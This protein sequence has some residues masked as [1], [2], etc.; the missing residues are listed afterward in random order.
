M[1]NEKE[2][3]MIGVI[4]LDDRWHY[5]YINE[6]AAAIVGRRPADLVGKVIWAE[7]PLAM[8]NAC[9]EQ[10]HKSFQHNREVHFE[11]YIQS[12][13]QW[14]Q[15]SAYPYEG[16]LHIRLH[17]Q[18]SMEMSFLQD[19]TVQMYVEHAQ[20]LI[21]L[22][23]RDGIFRYVSPAIQRLLGFEVDEILGIHIFA[24]CHPED[25]EALRGSFTEEDGIFLNNDQ[26]IITCRFL[27]KNGWYVWFEMNYKWM[28]GEEGERSQK[29]CIWR[30]ITERKVVE[31]RFVQAQRLGQFGS[32]EREITKNYIL[33]SDEIYRIHGLVPQEQM[34]LRDA[35]QLILPE[36][37]EKVGLAV[38]TA[39]RQGRVEVEYR[40]TRADGELRY[41]RTQI[42]RCRSDSNRLIVR[43]L[44]HDITGHK[45]IE[46][47]LKKS[48]ANLQI[49]QE[50]AGLGHYSWDVIR[51]E[52]QWSDEL[53]TLLHIQRDSYTSQ[54]DLFIH[55]VHPDDM[56]KVKEALRVALQMGSL[57]MTVR[58]IVDE[59]VRTIHTM[60]KTSYDEWG[61]PL[62]VFG[63]VQ[64]I[65]L[66]K[67]TE[68]LLRRT[69][70]LNVAGQLAAGI[71]HEIRNPLTALKGFAK[72]MCHANEDSRLRYFQIM[73][74]EFNR[75]ELIL[76]E[77]LILA[78]P[79]VLAYQL[80][81]VIAILR[82][83]IEL[84]NTE[85]IISNVIIDLTSELDLPLVRSESSQLKQV[86][87]NVIKNAI[88]AM[89]TGGNLRIIVRK[90]ANQVAFFFEDQGQGI[91]EERLPRIG[92]P[93]YTTKEKGTGL[94]M[95]VSFAI[96]DEHQGHIE[97]QSKLGVGTTVLIQLPASV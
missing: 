42:E 39:V 31:E 15:V 28:L 61:R 16:H 25:I 10:F 12:N 85:A 76:G 78:K 47:E 89:P 44:I 90:M 5:T 19:R 79:Q 30:D 70:K 50:I 34:N 59:E 80:H 75:I 65:T 14:F 48:K 97:Y 40:I 91:S 86:F 74:E 51:N 60:A 73:Q 27:H 37:R 66:Q 77:L 58:I 1:A 62:R 35:I 57:D 21:T 53:F 2:S 17:K 20:D 45:L 81:D 22:T 93:F 13:N 41:I 67:Q 23:T 4:I 96:I 49:A 54:M 83:V 69:E 87:I 64:D 55:I 36:D 88:E 43:G 6:Y 24:Y 71:A 56:L 32:F 3:T 8:R 38:E 52:L 63:T 84:L 68:E 72:L 26:G 29:L 94:G 46:E 9:Y 95:M 82:E 92:E 18:V 11:E 33:W 7:F